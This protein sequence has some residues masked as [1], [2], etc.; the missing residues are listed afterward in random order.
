MRNRLVVLASGEG[1]LLAHL[2]D[3]CAAGQ[4]D[5]EI[6]AVGA[7]RFGT[8]AI[9]RAQAA[10]IETFVC[11]VTDYQDRDAWDKALTRTCAKLRP[12][13]IVSAGFLK[14]FGPAFL[15]E[16]AGRCINSHPA[17]LP[18]FPGLHGIGDA[19]AYGVKVTGCTVFLVDSGLD[20]GPIVAQAAVP[21]QDGDDE[22][23]LTER[24][25]ATERQLLSQTVADMIAC[26]WSV[27]GRQVKIGRSKKGE[28]AGAPGCHHQG[29]HQRLRQERA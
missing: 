29:D 11:R 26:G 21:V 3:A 10:G 24:V 27:S 13:L 5:A 28:S 15:G 2:I 25:K 9:R 7:D 8:N 4:V 14:L 23:T 12:D 1:T 17:L 18:S 20:S 16:F 22:E 6:V 19:L